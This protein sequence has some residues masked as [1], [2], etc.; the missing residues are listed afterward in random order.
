MGG[1]GLWGGGVVVGG[2]IGKKTP[3]LSELLQIYSSSRSLRSASER[4]TDLPCT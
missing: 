2:G 3:Y 1:G 4:N